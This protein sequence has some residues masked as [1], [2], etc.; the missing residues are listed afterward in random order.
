LDSLANQPHQYDDYSIYKAFRAKSMNDKYQESEYKNS[1]EKSI[2]EETYEQ[3][4]LWLMNKAIMLNVP[5]NQLLTFL[6]MKK[7]RNF[8][9]HSDIFDFF[10]DS[11]TSFKYSL[12]DLLK[13]HEVQDMLEPNE[14]E[15]LNKI[16]LTYFRHTIE[17]IQTL[18]TRANASV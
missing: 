7:V 15:A 3:Y 6:W 14:I 8:T 13:K 12:L 17:E 9:C 2:D 1:F 16:Y 11:R 10:N 5:I 18:E 4:Y